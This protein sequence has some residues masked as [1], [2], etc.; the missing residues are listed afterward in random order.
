VN[1]LWSTVLRVGQPQ[2]VAVQPG[3]ELDLRGAALDVSAD[4]DSANVPLQLW[5]EYD[6]QSALLGTLRPGRCDQ[7]SLDVALHSSEAMVYTLRL[8]TARQGKRTSRDVAVGGS[9]CSVEDF[10]V[11]VIGESLRANVEEGDAE[12]QDG[13]DDDHEHAQCQV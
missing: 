3:I 8:T 7:L 9:E 1:Q 5:L 10:A 2:Q 13:K 11:H 6:A 12:G 4:C